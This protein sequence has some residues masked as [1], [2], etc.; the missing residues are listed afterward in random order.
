MQSSGPH[1]P[2][3]EIVDSTFRGTSLCAIDGAVV[4]QPDAVVKP[5]KPAT[6]KCFVLAGIATPQFETREMKPL[7]FRR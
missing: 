5:I 7:Q 6:N 1:I 4:E 3:A 2:N